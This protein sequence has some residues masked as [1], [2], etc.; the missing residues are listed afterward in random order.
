MTAHHKYW[1]RLGLLIVLVAAL[2][3]AWKFTPLSEYANPDYIRSL[4]EKVRDTPWSVPI[5]IAIYTVGTLIF[6]PH[7]AMTAVIALTFAPLTA[8]FICMTGSLISSSIGYLIGRQFGL[9]F[10]EVL[11]GN[12]AKKIADYVK[13][14]G[15]LGITLLR[16][17]PIAPYVVVNIT[18]AM[19]G[20]PYLTFIAATF[21]SALPGTAAAS[22]LGFSIMEVWDDPT[23]E[24][25]ML[26]GG[27]FAG[28]LTI[29]GLSH[30]ANRW[31]QKNKT[32]G[33]HG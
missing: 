9:S 28:W 32:A 14:G 6:F 12:T 26:I 17:L 5:A 29:V 24:N 3:L 15:I 20:V 22:L 13:K 10:M 7:V 16:M 2:V 33:A 25:M 18:L 30:L 4:F 1:L 19:L 8:F 21:L 11:I 23:P 27:G 31:W